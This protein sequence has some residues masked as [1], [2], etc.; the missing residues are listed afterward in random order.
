VNP[1][2]PRR[3][4]LRNAVDLGLGQVAT[5]LL[6]VVL[7]AAI[8][9]TLN[10]VDFGLM[11]LITVITTFS[12]VVID[13]GHGPLIIRESARH[14]ERTG[15]LMGSAFTARSMCALVACV[16]VVTAM[17]MLGYAPYTLLLA[18]LMIL[19]YLPQ[20]LGMSLG[21]AFRSHGRM[22][23]D[24]QLNVAFKLAALMSIVAC[25]ALGGRLLGLVFAWGIAGC[26]CL[27]IGIVMYR[28]L[29]LPRL[30]TT[31][32]TVR[33]LLH[34]GTPIFAM[35][36]A[37]AV[38]PLINTNILYKMT[39]PVVVGWYGAAWTIAGTLIA[40]ATVL[41][42][43]M[44]PNLSTAAG[45][46]ATFRR[47][48]TAS[49]RPLLLIAVLA[50]VGTYQFADVPIAIIYGVPKFAPAVDALRTFAPVLLLLYIDLFLSM[51]NLA[52][53]KA[54][55]MAGAKV[56][57]VVLTT[58]LALFLVPICQQ[59][60]GNGGLGV[61]YALLISEFVPII[62][63]GLILREVIDGR[64]IGDV[65]RAVLAGVLTLLMFWL[66]PPFTPWL[67]IPGCV[68]AFAAFSL[69]VGALRGSDVEM[70]TSR[71]RKPQPQS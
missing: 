29:H 38:E 42:T 63:N 60:F 49:F 46:Q 35:S 31:L 34:D 69:L 51:A 52:M 37:I 54:G 25:L 50:A 33:M 44:Y 61:M 26:L 43:V 64:M 7:N 21:W 2:T 15:E 40:P 24:A 57:S 39:S 45:D 3:G 67:G 18:G 23:R 70:V 6:T 16:L 68:L 1:K 62:A 20:Y 13:W 53:G 4:V 59:R 5:T 36:L 41:S 10:P 71:F 11:Y 28:A 66:L 32:S 9:R 12:Y 14:P 22:D 17:W 58:G 65:C 47:T 8:A 30:T 27:I 48:F 56:V 19:T 55:R